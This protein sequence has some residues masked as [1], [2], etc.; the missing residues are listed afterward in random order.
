MFFELLGLGTLEELSIGFML[1]PK[2]AIS[3]GSPT[4][5][6]NPYYLPLFFFFFFLKKKKKPK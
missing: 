6:N 4:W 1:W 5:A 3:W 2:E